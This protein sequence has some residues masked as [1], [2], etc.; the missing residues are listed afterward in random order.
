LTS[1]AFLNEK[2]GKK[3]EENN[4]VLLEFLCS[5]LIVFQNTAR[6]EEF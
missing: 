5:S 4:Y 6:A 2:V 1:E 3:N